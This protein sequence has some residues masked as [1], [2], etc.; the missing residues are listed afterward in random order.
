M[1]NPLKQCD[2]FNGLPLAVIFEAVQVVL[3]I[4]VRTGMKVPACAISAS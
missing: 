1:S 3:G 2:Q 4:L